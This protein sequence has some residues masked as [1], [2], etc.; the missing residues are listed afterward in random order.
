M[1]INVT[2]PDLPEYAISDEVVYYEISIPGVN[3]EN[4]R[5]T[6]EL[7]TKVVPG[8]TSNLDF[9]ALREGAALY[10]GYIRLE[11]LPPLNY[12][13]VNE[14]LK[15]KITVKVGND[16]DYAEE[17]L[18][19]SPSRGGWIKTIDQEFYPV[20]IFGKVYPKAGSTNSPFVSVSPSSGMLWYQSGKY[21][22]SFSRG[23]Y[24]T[25]PLCK[26]IGENL[27]GMVAGDSCNITVERTGHNKGELIVYNALNGE[28][29]KR[30]PAHKGPFYSKVK[31]NGN[32]DTVCFSRQSE[33]F[34][35]LYQY[36]IGSE[37]KLITS[38]NGGM[39]RV[40]QLPNGNPGLLGLP[41][42]IKDAVKNKMV[43]PKLIADYLEVDDMGLW[44]VAQSSS[45]NP[46][47]YRYEWDTSKE[48]FYFSFEVSLT[49][50]LGPV[51]RPTQLLATS[52]SCGVAFIVN[53]RST[54][55]KLHVVTPLKVQHV[56]FNK[57][58]HS[59]YGGTTNE[60]KFTSGISW[61]NDTIAPFNQ[62]ATIQV[63][64]QRKRKITLKMNNGE[65][66]SATVNAQGRANIPVKVLN[67]SRKFILA[68]R[69]LFGSDFG[70][71]KLTSPPEKSKTIHA[72]KTLIWNTVQT[73]GKVKIGLGSAEEQGKKNKIE[74]LT[75]I[76]PFTG[77]KLTGVLSS[78]GT[79]WTRAIAPMARLSYLE[80]SFSYPN[81]D[82]IIAIA[83]IGEKVWLL[84]RMN[85][86]KHR[87]M[88]WDGS[89]LEIG[90]EVGDAISLAALS[91][92][93]VAIFCPTEGNGRNLSVRIA[94]LNLDGDAVPLKE[95]CYFSSCSHGPGRIWVSGKNKDLR[96][97]IITLDKNGKQESGII[98]PK[99]DYDDILFTG[100]NGQAWG[101][102]FT[103][104][105]TPSQVLLW[106]DPKKEP[107]M[108]QYGG[109]TGVA[110]Y[111]G[112]KQAS[113]LTRTYSKSIRCREYIKE[114]GKLRALTD[115][116]FPEHCS[117]FKHLEF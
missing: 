6:L 65:S 89:T 43:S 86:K 5:V 17:E 94:T 71:S 84:E 62:N 57:Q 70:Y 32:T 98:K 90:K 8:V 1:A 91:E 11:N 101:F 95:F 83:P 22:K 48:C 50:P 49:G 110:I 88:R 77:A 114:D 26:L 27:I 75:I 99:Y 112:P 63:I 81:V 59:V 7:L 30:Y 56:N 93:R 103:A 109:D 106:S 64:S 80:T 117:L 31:K 69:N 73:T 113:V 76:P 36:T 67:E 39:R 102:K 97:T 28:V 58:I 44:L 78:K 24:E 96:K 4:T 51:D 38:W 53:N 12:Q 19:I 46:K 29:V 61:C 54:K 52:R 14:E 20:S 108:A 21:L 100:S 25:K 15:I 60:W 42:K 92:E 47:A 68:E 34:T 3:P 37:P 33:G 41:G 105:A 79:L 116:F 72:C 87:I 82:K 13:P 111:A 10:R 35:E 74:L 115:A 107:A 18:R 23:S 2:F 9:V 40:L 45:R 85:I 55:G 104:G 16:T 66:I